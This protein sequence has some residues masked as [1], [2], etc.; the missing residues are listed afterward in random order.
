LFCA[1]RTKRL[2][3]TV[4]SIQWYLDCP[5]NTRNAGTLGRLFYF[6]SVGQVNNNDEDISVSPAE[7]H[8]HVSDPCVADDQV[9][10][11]QESSQENQARAQYSLNNDISTE[12]VGPL[13]EL[14]EVGT[15]EDALCA[16]DVVDEEVEKFHAYDHCCTDD[17]GEA[18]QLATDH[19]QDDMVE[20]NQVVYDDSFHPSNNTEY[21]M[22]PEPMDDCDEVGGFEDDHCVKE[23]IAPALESTEIL[24]CF[25]F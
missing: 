25:P 18:R 9:E 19:F 5:W 23:T 13:L 11:R 17:H 2:L 24:F 12:V 1:N 10:T 21:P 3:E 8:E 15:S 7:Q 6:F 16:C 14:G 20:Q 22:A 4:P